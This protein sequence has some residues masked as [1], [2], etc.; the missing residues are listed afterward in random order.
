MKMDG[1]KLKEVFKKIPSAAFALAFLLII[2]TIFTD[3]FW[4]TENFIN[5]AQQATVL[6]ILSLGMTLVILSEGID[7]SVGALVSLCGVV[8]AVYLHKGVGIFGAVL[9]SVGVGVAAGIVNG[10]FIAKAGLPPFVVTLGTMGMC[11]GIA[12]VITQGSSIPGFSDAFRF[13][14]SGFIFK[15][16]LPALILAFLVLI[17]YVLLYHTRFGTYVFSI[18]GN[19]E[20]VNLAGV[21]LVLQKA[22]I[23]VVAGAFGGVGALIMTSRMNA[24]HPWVTMGMEFD[25]IVSVILG[26]TSFFMGKGNPFG[27]LIGAATIAILKNGMNILGVPIALQVAFVGVFLILAVIYDSLKG[28]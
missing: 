1:E 11:Q 5:L 20:A 26:G 7:L 19:P 13:I 21:N 25:A 15:I 9:I 2:Y 8:V 28:E 27:S 10:F 14:A 16:P 3:L 6:A 12:L 17:T 18:G 22:L 24:A 4:T 23:Y